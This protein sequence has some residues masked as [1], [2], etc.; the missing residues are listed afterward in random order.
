MRR[1]IYIIMI[2]GVLIACSE[3]R[4]H[5]EMLDCIDTLMNNHPDSA[6]QILDSL[7][8]EKPHWSRSQRMRYD[9]LHLKAENKAF[10]PLTSDS[11]A[12]DLVSYYDTW[13]NANERMMAHYLLGC[14][15]RDKGDSPRAI[16]AYQKA[17]SQ[18]DTTA[19]DCDFY[20]LS[21]VYAQMAGVFHQQLLFTNEINARKLSTHFANYSKDSLLVIL[22]LSKSA[23]AYLLLNKKDSAET[24]LKKVWHLYQKGHYVQQTLQASTTLIYLYVQEPNKNY[25]AKKLMDEYEAK[26]ILFDNN[27]ELSGA[28]KQYY[29]YKG[30]YYD[31]VDLLD[32]AE[33][34]YR[35]VY[36]P[37]MPFVAKDPMY[38]G[39][40]SVF[41][42]R[43]QADSIAKYAQLY[44]DANDSSIAIKD[45]ELTA[46][47]AATYNYSLYQKEARENEIKANNTRIALI[48]ILAFIIII[49]IILWNRYQKIKKRKQQEFIALNTK[50]QNAT[51][52]Y[53]KNLR[54]LQILDNAH[55]GVIANIQE[56]LDRKKVE[57]SRLSELSAEYESEKTRLEEEN[58]KL[59]ES[60]KI[61][62]RQKGLPNY[63]ENTQLFMETEIVKHFKTLEMIPLSKILEDN[64]TKLTTEVASF[65]PQLLNDLNLSPKMTKQK[66]RVCLLVILKIQDSCI[67]NW[68]NLKASRISNIKSELNQEMFN[69]SSARTLYNNLRQKYNI[70]SNGK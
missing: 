3:G 47:M 65:F 4:E 57:S 59:T 40:L 66:I 24:L 20:T 26:S 43:H 12:K 64:W 18:A 22:N 15:Y 56:E 48:M 14:V 52:E 69:D 9:L 63:L 68:L 39:L 23:G 2:V 5:A 37:G 19:T 41:M 31:N 21:C 55:Q 17:I 10:V 8:S 32:S 67:A 46:Q 25:E 38:K 36:H 1:I 50:Y 58:S 70:L 29:Y 28:R 45:Q 33:Y 30:Q 42:K 62:E 51:N 6:L 61:L 60:L 11:V 27:H 54:I 49:S 44:C 13:G 34:Y 35:K 53:N 16:D 7:K